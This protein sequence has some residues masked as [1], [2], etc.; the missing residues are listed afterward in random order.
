M[1]RA[2]DGFEGL[3]FMQEKESEGARLSYDGRLVRIEG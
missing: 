2:R 3:F 1:R